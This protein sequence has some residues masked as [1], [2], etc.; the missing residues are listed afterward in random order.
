MEYKYQIL[1][2]PAFSTKSIEFKLTETKI[3]S[4]NNLQ[5]MGQE[6]SLAYTVSM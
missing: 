6:E 2:P 4:Q 5:G 1:N 3:N